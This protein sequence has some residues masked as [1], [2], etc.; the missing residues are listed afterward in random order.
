MRI[1]K[2]WK[3]ITAVL[4]AAGMLLGGCGSAAQEKT[5]ADSEAAGAA[6]ASSVE[7]V[8]ETVVENVVSE[9][10]AEEKGE[11]A[12][13]DTVSAS[14][15]ETEV[16]AAAEKEDVIRIGALSGPTAM[17][18][19]ELMDRAEA[20]ETVN[21][22]AFAELS[23]EASAF[24]APLVQGELD[25]AV[26]PSNL[27]SVVYNKTEGGIKVLAAAVLGVQYIVERGESIQSVAD[28]SGKTI[29]ATG[30][31]A[32]PEAVLRTVLKGN[33]LE[34]DT[35]VTMHWCADTTEALSYVAADEAA[36]AM[37]PQP[38]ATAAGAKVE[39]LHTALDLSE[40]WK[41]LDNGSEVVTAVAVVRKA[42]AE[43]HPEAVASFME[44]Y[45]ASAACVESD[46]DTTAERIEKYGILPAAAL[47][48]KALPSCSIV[49]IEGEEMKTMLSGYLQILA[50]ND[51]AMVG[52]SLPKDDF[53][54]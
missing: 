46:P 43:E 1:N 53:Y 26:I 45:R 4:L 10:A 15:V 18:L 29:Y 7:T 20:G 32:V 22:Y 31:G 12:V 38:F 5:Q 34:M 19:V 42:F 30:Q 6:A 41:A 11:E 39:G 44:E 48:K 16:Q 35:D 23:T 2:T 21:T 47:A 8:E 27:A 33:G 37:L 14:S 51:P 13:I 36:I 17:G 25:I 24:V 9:S 54:E 50:D 52:G 40:E 49:C 28:L 3:A